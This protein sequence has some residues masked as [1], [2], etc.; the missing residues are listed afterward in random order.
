MSFKEKLIKAISEIP[1]A[2]ISYLK[3]I[4]NEQKGSIIILGNGG[5]SAICSHI[6]EDYTKVLKKRTLT[7]TDAA[8]L[9]C[10]S[11]DY[12]YENAYEQFLKEYADEDTLVIL[13]S[14][15]GNSPNIVK[16]AK[17]C[18]SKNLKLIT[19]T[20]FKSY[21]DLRSVLSNSSTSNWLTELWVNSEEYGIVELTH[22][23]FL[24][25][26]C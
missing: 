18:V 21:N 7:F 20:G 19:L 13:I 23:A 14:S 6:A 9:T 16:C 2:K 3:K 8:R 15:S 26:I 12:G 5:S 22:E 1:D 11:N 4:I 24:H 17:Y 10:Y 25:S